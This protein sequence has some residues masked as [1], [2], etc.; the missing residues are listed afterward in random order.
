MIRVRIAA[1]KQWREVE[2]QEGMKVRD[3]I[4]RF[5]Y[6]PASTI[7]SLNGV[8]AE[9][10]KELKDGDELVLVPVVGGG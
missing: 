5:R 3:V 7:I 8:P 10:S 4:E 9:E 2:Y 1:S 6:H